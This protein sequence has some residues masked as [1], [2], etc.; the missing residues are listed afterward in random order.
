MRFGMTPRH[1]VWVIRDAATAGAQQTATDRARRATSRPRPRAYSSAE[2][3]IAS[4]TLV[5][6]PSLPRV[7]KFGE[8][9]AAPSDTL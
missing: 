7:V 5:K 3:R 9:L 1:R 4:R 2:M 6:L 8:A